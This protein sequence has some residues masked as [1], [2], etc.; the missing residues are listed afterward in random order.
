DGW[1]VRFGLNPRND[2][3]ATRDPDRDGVDNRNEFLTRSNPRAADTNH[4]GVID[5]SDDPDGDGVPTAVEQNLGLDP[6]RAD[7][8]P[9]QREPS[10]GGQDATTPGPSADVLL[11]AHRSGVELDEPAATDG[12]LDSDGDGLP[13]AVELRLG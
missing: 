1:E 4:D 2:L 5:G 3:D 10:R 13:N 12:A 6:A 8:P 7:T 11:A 9:S